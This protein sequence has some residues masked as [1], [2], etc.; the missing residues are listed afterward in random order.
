MA[1]WYRALRR[2]YSFSSA[3]SMMVR[4]HA[5]AVLAD[6]SAAVL[7]VLAAEHTAPGDSGVA[8]CDDGRGG[9]G[10]R[11]GRASVCAARGYAQHHLLEPSHLLLER[12]HLCVGAGRSL[13]SLLDLEPH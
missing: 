13:L 2:R 9:S 6:A 8:T 1:S 4:V 10:G 12:R 7:A 5:S 11:T 3:C